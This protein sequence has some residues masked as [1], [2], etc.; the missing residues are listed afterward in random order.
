MIISMTFLLQVGRT[1]NWSTLHSIPAGMVSINAAV[2]PATQTSGD[3]AA[4]GER[5][6]AV[7]VRTGISAPRQPA[8]IIA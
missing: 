3:P 6:I 8:R 4:E 5:I 1:K 2:M 7:T